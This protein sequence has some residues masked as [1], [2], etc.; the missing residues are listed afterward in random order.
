MKF[1]VRIAVL[2]SAFA[3]PVLPAVAQAPVAAVANA[4]DAR[5]T[6]FL[7]GEF[8]EWVK[9]QPQLA[10]RLGIK[11][12]GDQWNDI[13]AAAAA[14]QVKWRQA[15][16]ARMKA[17]IDRSKLS[18]EGQVNYDIWA[19]EAERAA[20]QNAGRLYR[21]PFNSRLNSVHTQAPDFLINT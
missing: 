9:L 20:M 12:G 7:D 11:A 16:A 2:M 15:S 5:L 6:A 3:L 21:A 10:T 18:G 13:S 8:A 19:L 14:A 1:T 17:S 4:E